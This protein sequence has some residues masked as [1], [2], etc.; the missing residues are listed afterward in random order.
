M[1]LEGALVRTGTHNRPPM[2]AR[3]LDLDHKNPDVWTHCSE[4][5]PSQT[6]PRLG[7]QQLSFRKKEMQS[8]TQLKPLAGLT[9]L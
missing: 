8:A 4:D 2:A 5:K 6:K 3:T 1:S 9:D 7:K